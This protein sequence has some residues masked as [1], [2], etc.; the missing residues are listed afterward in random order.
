MHERRTATLPAEIQ[1]ETG[2]RGFATVWFH[3]QKYRIDDPQKQAQWAL[4]VLPKRGQT[5]GVIG[6][7]DS[8]S[9]SGGRPIP[10]WSVINLASP[11]SFHVT[12]NV[13]LVSHF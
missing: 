12:G 5:A 2:M 4:M 11:D 9:S 1:T 13:Q 10:L 8:F 6:T 3:F 7:I